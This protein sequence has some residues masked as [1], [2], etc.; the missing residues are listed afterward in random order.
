MTSP[1]LNSF[2][3]HSA[4]PEWLQKELSD[5]SIH[6]A[7]SDLAMCQERLAHYGIPL[8]TLVKDRL[9]LMEQ[10]EKRHS[11]Y[12]YETFDAAS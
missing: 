1:D 11:E 2:E 10:R 8:P 6:F 12:A 3:P 4:V 9:T 7:T 5:P